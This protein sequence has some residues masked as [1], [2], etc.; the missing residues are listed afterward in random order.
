MISLV[1][2]TESVDESWGGSMPCLLFLVIVR[3]G[4]EN[5]TAAC[6]DSA[7]AFFLCSGTDLLLM[8]DGLMFSNLVS[9]LIRYNWHS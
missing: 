6:D 7:Y 5:I 1:E 2:L 9:A 4:G 8:L 3:C